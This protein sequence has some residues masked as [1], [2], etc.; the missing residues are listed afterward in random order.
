[1]IR[2]E[3]VGEHIRVSND[4]Q[5]DATAKPILMTLKEVSVGVKPNG[6]P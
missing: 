5:K 6:K 2:I 3:K 1:M 4:K